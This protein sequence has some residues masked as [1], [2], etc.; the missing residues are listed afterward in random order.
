MA[1]GGRALPS[2]AAS[3]ATPSS[4]DPREVALRNMVRLHPAA[5]SYPGDLLITQMTEPPKVTD[6]S[7]MNSWSVRLPRR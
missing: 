5:L 3:S 6:S 7:R 1:Q 2:L 4:P